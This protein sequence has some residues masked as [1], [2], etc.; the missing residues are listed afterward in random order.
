MKLSVVVPSYKNPMR[1]DRCLQALN[2]KKRDVDEVLVVSDFSPTQKVEEEVAKRH[3]VKFYAQPERSG[4]ASNI[5]DGI[6]KTSGDIVI[7]LNSDA[8]ILSLQGGYILQTFAKNPKLGVMGAKLLF[9]NGM[10]QHAGG[11][12]I[13]I[14]TG[15]YG[16][17]KPDH[18]AFNKK[19]FCPWVTG[20]LIA[21][22]RK[23]WKDLG[24]FDES[25]WFGCEDT[26]FCFDAWEKDWQVLYDPQLAAIHEEGG[27]RND[28]VA[29]DELDRFRVKLEFE[30]GMVRLKREMQYRPWNE[31]FRKVWEANGSQKRL[32][33]ER[34]GAIGDVVAVSAALKGLHERLPDWSINFRA[35]LPPLDV[36][37]DN[38]HIHGGSPKAV[39][40]FARVVTLNA[41]HEMKPE[42]NLYEVYKQEIE[43]QLSIKFPLGKPEI[44]SREWDWHSLLARYSQD[45]VFSQEEDGQI[46]VR[47]YAVIHPGQ[48][49]WRGRNMTPHFWAEIAHG[50]MKMNLFVVVVGGKND[51]Q[52]QHPQVLDLRDKTTIQELHQLI[53]HA[54]IF[55][56]P[57]SFP[58]HCAQATETPFVGV[59]TATDPDKFI[60]PDINGTPRCASIYPKTGC[61]FCYKDQV[62]PV[63]MLECPKN[64]DYECT[65]NID[66]KDAVM[67]AHRIF[68]P[69]PG[70]SLVKP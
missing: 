12:V 47:P 39:D 56:G 30:K 2:W 19:Y 34:S 54:K 18:P 53:S 70:L 48:T 6:E 45:L 36:L 24:G 26:K 14:E 7:L 3:K 35:N 69:K 65:W 57:D 42:V 44:Y 5:N 60:H 20:A 58:L 10:V 28:R 43:S 59:F 55:V 16:W 37:T 61:F 23:T 49:H 9:P 66:P 31:T 4:Y 38:P 50:L 15:H 67:A 27:T 64:K 68:A 62:P 21:V 41:A 52:I 29:L 40:P 22:N 8:H 32:I 13:W 51:W 11:F 1:L 17:Q 63:W 25:Y 46:E 33:L